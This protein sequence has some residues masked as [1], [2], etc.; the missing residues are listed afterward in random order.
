MMSVL[1]SIFRGEEPRGQRFGHDRIVGRKQRSVEEGGHNWLEYEIELQRGEKVPNSTLTIRVDPDTNLPATMKMAFA[2]RTLQFAFDY[3][4]EGPADIY[5]LGVPRDTPLDDRMPGDDLKRILNALAVGNRELDNY[6]AAISRNGRVE[7][8]AWRRGNRWR[9]ARCTPPPR[10]DEVPTDEAQLAAWWR[11]RLRQ[12]PPVPTFVCDGQR[13]YRRKSEAR[14]DGS[15]RQTWSVE[16]T[17]GPG[18]EAGHWAA[19]GNFSGINWP[20][21]E[22]AAY[23]TPATGPRIKL[24]LDSTGARRPGRQHLARTDWWW[25]C[26]RHLQRIP[27]PQPPLARSTARLRGSAARAFPGLAGGV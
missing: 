4:A 11:K 13:V 6:F 5:A 20:L 21:I 23:Q 15:D 8:L 3:P 9:L 16:K 18:P 19:N 14:P 1:N 22:L 27:L 10:P 2:E 17:L 7:L 25:I 26:C 12:A 24:R